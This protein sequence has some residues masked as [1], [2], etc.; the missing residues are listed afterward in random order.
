MDCIDKH[1]RVEEDQTQGK[2]KTKVFPPKRRDTQPERYNHSWSRREFAN[3]S[4]KANAQ[5]VNSV[6]KESVYQILE[7]IKNESYF[8]WPNKKG[9]DP[10][11]HNQSLYCQY[12]QDRGHTTEDYK[13]LRDH[14]D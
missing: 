2:G 11:K 7:K 8:K 13:T 14:L 4:S 6:F 12:H 3:Q 10:S 9:G 1:K 5:V